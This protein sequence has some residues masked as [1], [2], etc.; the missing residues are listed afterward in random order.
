MPASPDKESQPNG[1]VSTGTGVPPSQTTSVFSAF[2]RWLVWWRQAGNPGLRSSLAAHPFLFGSLFVLQGYAKLQ[3]MGC[4]QDLFLDLTAVLTAILVLQ[5]VFIFFVRQPR[6]PALLASLCIVFFCFFGDW[7]MQLEECLLGSRWFW[8]ARMRWMLPVAGTVFLALFTWV[9]RTPRALVTTRRYLDAVSALLVAFTL[10]GIFR[11]PPQPVFQPGELANVPMDVGGHPPDIYFIL[12]DAYTSP[13]SLKAYWGYDNSAFVNCLTGLGFHVLKNAHCNATFTPICLSTYLNMNYP[14]PL[15]RNWPMIS[16][17]A[18]FCQIIRQAEAPA[19][20]K[21]SG[22]DVRSLSIFDVA[23]QRRF[24]NYPGIS[25]PTLG[26][27]L[28]ARLALV[29]LL[30]TPPCASYGDTNLKLFSLLPRIAAERTGKPKF[31]YAHLM[32]PHPPYF[33]DE[34]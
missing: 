1:V 22:Y 29:M 14:P 23:G 18:W 33:F 7:R 21:A 6:K 25:G 28:W 15:P 5:I 26:G 16:Q 13:E 8:L 27:V 19:R 31:V 3:P 4:R 11:A 24:Y 20:L 9:L 32:I 34:K 10:A 17:V 30:N 12:T 2:I